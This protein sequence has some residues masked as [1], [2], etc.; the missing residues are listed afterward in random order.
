M[1][2]RGFN[3]RIEIWST[4]N[5]SDGFGGSKVTSTLLSNSWANIKTYQ[6]GK[7]N[8]L[9][10]FGIVDANNSILIT[11]RKRN[12]LVYN[13]ETMYV[14]YRG[15]SYT[16]STAPTNIN[17]NDSYITFIGSTNSKKGN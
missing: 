8:N 12:D 5:V 9:T 11:V 14:K 10:D 17:F 16:I 1:R 13:V 6:A 2:V 4:A 3:K 15:V 7:G